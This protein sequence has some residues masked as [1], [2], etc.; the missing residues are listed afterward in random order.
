[1]AFGENKTGAVASCVEG[2]ISDLC[3]ASY[4]QEHENTVV[5]LDAAAAMGESS[6]T[7]ILS[8]QLG[9]NRWHD[10]EPSSSYLPNSKFV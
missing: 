4:L 10:C 1:V 7:Q 2:G 3:A 8:F 5:H 6:T 9:V